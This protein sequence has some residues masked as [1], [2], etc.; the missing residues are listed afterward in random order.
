MTPVDLTAKIKKN[1]DIRIGHVRDRLSNYKWSM[2]VRYIVR[3]GFPYS[4]YPRLYGDICSLVGDVN[5]LTLEIIYPNFWERI[6]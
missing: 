6:T 3:N 1:K 4:V 5:D 2:S